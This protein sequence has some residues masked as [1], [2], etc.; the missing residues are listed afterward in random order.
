MAEENV[1]IIGGGIAGLCAALELA[2]FGIGVELV[3]KEDALGGHARQFTCKATDRCVKCGA[4]I[5][6]EKLKDVA[7]NT[8][9]KVRLGSCVEKIT[10]SGRFSVGISDNR[11]LNQSC[12]VDAV[13]IASGFTPFTPDGKP[14]GYNRFKNVI[15]NLDLERALRKR[16]LVK[17]FSDDR[18]PKKIA[19][20]QC[21]GSRDA[22]LNH[23]WCSRVCCGS[24]LRMSSLIKSRQPEAE[25]TI[26]Y[27]DIQSFGRDFQDFL[28]KIKADVRL[29]RAIPADVLET[30]DDRLL[31]TYFDSAARESREEIFDLVASLDW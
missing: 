11:G 1:L 8:K 2:R 23:L 22:K 19:F 13:I 31:I 18:A 30:E 20:I 16:G 21:V 14:Y 26:F 28:N 5:V 10:D 12:D 9:I 7:D 3:E 25:M 27:M 29:I 4:C 17:R 6:E 24:A 15:S